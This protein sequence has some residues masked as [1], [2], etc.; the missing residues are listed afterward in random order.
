MPQLTHT[1]VTFTWWHLWRGT[2]A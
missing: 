2:K 1:T